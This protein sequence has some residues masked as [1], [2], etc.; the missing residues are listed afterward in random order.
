MCYVIKS[1]LYQE[2]AKRCC[3][4]SVCLVLAIKVWRQLVFLTILLS[5]QRSLWIKPVCKSCTF[6]QLMF[7]AQS[8]IKCLATKDLL[9]LLPNNAFFKAIKVSSFDPEVQLVEWSL[10]T[11]KD[12]CSSPAIINFYKEY[13]LSINCIEKTKLNK[14]KEAGSGSF[15]MVLNIV[16]RRSSS[17]RSRELKTILEKKCDKVNFLSSF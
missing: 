13:L 10:P 17:N 12:L 5:L 7:T 3:Q 9:S 2:M 6:V 16:F 1:R 15:K 4:Q 11:P 8:E 14:E